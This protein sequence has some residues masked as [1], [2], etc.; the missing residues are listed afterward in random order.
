MK[1]VINHDRH[2]LFT[3][4]ILGAFAELAL[5]MMGELPAA[6]PKTEPVAPVRPAPVPPPTYAREHST[7]QTVTHLYSRSFF[8]DPYQF[9]EVVRPK[10]P[11]SKED[12]PNGG[13]VF[14]ALRQWFAQ[15]G[16]DMDPTNGKSMFG[17]DDGRLLVRASSADLDTI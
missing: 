8:V 2:F 7:E 3:V 16:V 9:H 15:L 5:P 12:S 13:E 17:H 14:K 11:I 6:V 1:A 4:L 10:L